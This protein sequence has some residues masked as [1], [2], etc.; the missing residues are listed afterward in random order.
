MPQAEAFLKEQEPY[1]PGAAA[2]FIGDAGNHV[3]VSPLPALLMYSRRTLYPVFHLPRDAAGEF[4]ARGVSLPPFFSLIQSGAPLHAMQGLAEDVDLL[5]ISLNRKG[6]FASSSCDYELHSFDGILPRDDRGLPGLV[7][8]RPEAAD[9]DCLFPLQQDYEVQ[10]VIPE[11]AVFNPAVCRRTLELL[12][13]EGT[14]LIA[15]LEGRIA[16]KININAQSFTRFQ[17]GGVYVIPQLRNLGIARA[18][19]AALIRKYGP[20]KQKFSLFVKKTNV[21]ARRVYRS[22]GFAKIADYRINYYLR[23]QS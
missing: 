22:I 21:P 4:M 10:E 13:G 20:L 5:E 18:M 16:G 7:I 14:M 19:T 8:R 6:F 2:R 11:G 17:I 9:I 3:W 12:V 15:E 23:A 1:C